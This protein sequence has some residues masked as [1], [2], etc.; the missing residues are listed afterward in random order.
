MVLTEG[1]EVKRWGLTD[2]VLL[3]TWPP[4]ELP[5]AVSSDYPLRS[6]ASPL[7]TPDP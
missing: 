4:D 5:P 1:A 3:G 2:S 7:S 6:V